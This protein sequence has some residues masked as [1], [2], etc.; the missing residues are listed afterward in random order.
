MLRSW[1]QSRT[2]DHPREG[3]ASQPGLGPWPPFPPLA[4]GGLG[5][6]S[7]A[8]TLTEPSLA[9]LSMG[10]P[11]GAG[12]TEDPALTSRGRHPVL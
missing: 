2:L 4:L 10:K 8:S 6:T 11:P 12:S 9:P 1:Q 7:H 3:H 5:F